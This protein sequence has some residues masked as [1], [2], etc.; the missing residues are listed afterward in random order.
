MRVRRHR[1]LGPA[2]A[3]PPGHAQVH[4]QIDLPFRNLGRRP[5]TQREANEFTDALDRFDAPSG[6]QFAQCGGILDEVGFPQTH[7]DN[8]VPGQHGSQPADDGLDFGQ[9]RHIRGQR[10]LR[11]GQA[12]RSDNP[13]HA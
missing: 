9:L 10:K 2:H 4:D 3:E 8:R 1:I 6:K 11:Q 13:G 12:R 5:W 7:R